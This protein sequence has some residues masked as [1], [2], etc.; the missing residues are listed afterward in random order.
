MLKYLEN[1][2]IL[3]IEP[4]NICQAACPQCPRELNKEFDKKANVSLSVTDLQKILPT[5]TIKNLE[6][7]F[8][9]GNYGDPAAGNALDIFR[10]FRSINPDIVLGMNTNGAL[11]SPRWWKQIGQCLDREQ[12]YVVFS[13]DG[14]EDTNHIYR[15]NVIWSKAIANIEAFIS[16]GGNAHWDMLVYKH[17]EHQVDQCEQLAKKLGFK[18]FRAKVSRRALVDNLEYPTN[19]KIPNLVQGEISCKALGEQSLY[20]DCYGRLHPCCWLGGQLKDFVTFDEVI[21]TWNSNPHPT[22][23]LICSSVNNVYKD[24]W[25]KETKLY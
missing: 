3:H 10:Y 17:N 14:L 9:C 7:M 2:K 23:K 21:P 22:C 1:V 8:L 15:K 19:W 6:K 20:I 18:W 16:A 25:Q 12:D 24:Q 13:L 5:A 11:Q 4:T